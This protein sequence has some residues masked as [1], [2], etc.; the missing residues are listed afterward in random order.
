MVIKRRERFRW[1]GNR[2]VR[3]VLRSYREAQ[4]GRPGRTLVGRQRVRG[5][6]LGTEHGGAVAVAHGGSVK[7]VLGMVA[8]VEARL[9]L[10]ARRH[11]LYD[12]V[13]ERV[14]RGHP[15]LLLPSVAEPHSD[16]LL[17]QL[18]AVREGGDLLGG[19]FRL[20]VE[21][22]LE[23]AL[24]R[25]LDRGPLLPFPALGGYL[26]YTGRRAGRRVRLLEP[27]LQQRLQL[28]HV[29]EAE[30]QRLEP[31][32]RRL[33]E[34]VPVEGA[35]RE[36]HV[37]LGEAELDPALLELSGERLEVVRGRGVLLPGALIP[38]VRVARVK[39]VADRRAR[40]PQVRVQPRLVVVE[41][42]MV[43]GMVRVQHPVH[44]RVVLL[45][46]G[47]RGRATARVV[48]GRGHDGRV[49]TRVRGRHPR[50]LVR[51]SAVMHRLVVGGGRRGGRG[52]RRRRDRRLHVQPGH[53]R[54]VRMVVRMVA[55]VVHAHRGRPVVAA[56]LQAHP[57]VRR[58]EAGRRRVR[59]AV[60][61]R[62]RRHLVMMMMMVVMLRRRHVLH[63][64][65]VGGAARRARGVATH[66]DIH[67]DRGTRT[68]IQLGR[69]CATNRHVRGSIV[70]SKK[71]LS[72]ISLHD[73]I[74]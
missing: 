20:F 19:G 8:L 53:V 61:R 54:L 41:L 35:E 16:H 74:R 11:A 1:R 66:S 17:L 67:P 32:Y 47:G 45:E 23:G 55:G 43:L 52:R 18:E 57:G 29:L 30:L 40:I 48:M 39:R 44:R 59:Q 70:F 68:T 37:R 58:R 7:V 49:P 31:A 14:R 46:G 71:R 10:V 12:P 28:A 56:R 2:I 60:R 9:A 72:N 38:V 25:H 64:P 6:A 24:H 22:L 36:A 69:H 63:L 42:G 34:H 73:F 62:G 3:R 13:A 4:R 15:L 33:G 65:G 50:R 5:E 51:P 26:V 27:L 21:M